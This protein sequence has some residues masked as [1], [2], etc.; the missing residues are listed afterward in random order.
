MIR[1]CRSSD[2]TLQVLLVR[3]MWR[4][5]LWRWPS[6][7]RSCR[8]RRRPSWRVEGSQCPEPPL[9]S[10]LTCLKVNDYT[11]HSHTWCYA[12]AEFVC[13]GQSALEPVGIHNRAFLSVNADVLF[14]L[15]MPQLQ[16][17]QAINFVIFFDR[18]TNR[19]SYWY[20]AL[21]IIFG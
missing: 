17:Q 11:Y 18:S 20:N 21:F 9:L 13:Q 7:T 6:R 10:S 1:S 4:P 19:W 2:I 8:T 12:H 15:F 14:P 5:Q 3:W 16:K